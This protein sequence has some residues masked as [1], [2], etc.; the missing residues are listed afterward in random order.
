MTRATRAF[1]TKL[2]SRKPKDP[3][4]SN[5]LIRGS[6]VRI[7]AGTLRADAGRPFPCHARARE[8]RAPRRGR[9]PPRQPVRTV[10]VRPPAGRG[11]R[12]AATL[13]PPGGLGD[14]CGFS[15][16]YVNVMAS[17]AVFLSMSGGAYALTIPRNSVGSRQLRERAVTRTKLAVAT[18][19]RDGSLRARGFRRSDLPAG[20]RG[21]RGVTG[22]R[23][24]TGS[25]GATGAT[26]RPGRAASPRSTRCRPAARSAAWSGRIAH[27]PTPPSL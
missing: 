9:K 2:D 22:A 5:L 19:V 21:A 17:V 25:R 1:P 15:P 20:P 16:R 8:R 12:V 11:G 27:S 3:A 7:P 14:V 4:K 23:G 26:G 18:Q 10:A 13:P 24:S 6:Q